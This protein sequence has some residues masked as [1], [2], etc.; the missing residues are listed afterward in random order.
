MKKTLHRHKNQQPLY[1]QLA[2]RLRAGIAAQEWQPGDLLPSETILSQD[3]GVSRGTV[4]K[5]IELLLQEG[6]AQRRQGVGTFVSRPAL[7]RQPGFLQGFAE[8]VLKQGRVPSQQLLELR[9]LQRD[10]AMQYGCHEPAV[11]LHR[12]RLVDDIPWAVHKSLI[13]L[14]VAGNIPALNTK[15]KRLREA[16]NFSLYQAIG[17]AGYVIDNAEESVQSRLASDAEAELLKIAAP[18][19]VMMVHRRTFD[20]D[21]QLLELVE[22]I[23]LGDSYTYDTRLVRTYGVA[24][25]ASVSLPE[26][27]QKTTTT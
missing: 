2:D 6:L 15:G 8:T 18:A 24:D 14:A 19:A 5:A 17:D 3:Y 7:H 26:Q 22:A 4:V 23:Y 9:Q 27:D 21:G 13:P 12:V 1:L 25:I 20:P 11:L 16:V 10:E